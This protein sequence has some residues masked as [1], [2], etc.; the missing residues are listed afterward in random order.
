VGVGLVEENRQQQ[1]QQA[2]PYGMEQ[3]T[4]TGLPGVVEAVF[5]GYLDFGLEEVA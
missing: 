2:D 3:A 4:A 1:E 5:L